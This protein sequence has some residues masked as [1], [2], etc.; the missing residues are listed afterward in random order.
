MR[1]IR[2]MIFI[3]LILLDFHSCISV[4]LREKEGKDGPLGIASLAQKIDP[5]FHVF[6]SKWKGVG[7]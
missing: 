6:V 5:A 3:R 1:N 7:F 4:P 2:R